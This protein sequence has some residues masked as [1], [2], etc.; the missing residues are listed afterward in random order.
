MKFAVTNRWTMVVAGLVQGGLMLSLHEWFRAF[1]HQA[2]DL[3]W[4][5]PAYALVVLAPITFNFL[6]DEFP[7]RQSLAGAAVATLPR[8]GSG[9]AGTRRAGN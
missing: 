6:R 5:A 2:S 8:R 9:G 1:G 3:V 4:S 7:L